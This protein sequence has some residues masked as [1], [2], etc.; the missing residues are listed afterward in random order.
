MGCKGNAFGAKGNRRTDKVWGLT[1][2]NLQN[3]LTVCQLS[4]NGTWFVYPFLPLN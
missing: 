1:I 3:R 2:S 4:L